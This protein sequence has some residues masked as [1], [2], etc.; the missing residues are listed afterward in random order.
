MYYGYGIYLYSSSNNTFHSII[1]QENDYYDLYIT[2]LSVSDCNNFFQNATG[3]GDRP[4]E[5]Y[6][7]SVDLQNK[8]LSELI[9]C[10]A[11]NSNITNITIIGSSTKRNNMLYVCRTENITVSKINSSYN[12]VGVYLSSSNSTTLQNI[13][14]NS[15]YEGIR[16]SSSSSNTLQN[17]T[18]NSNNYGIRLS[19]SDNNTLQNITSNYNNYYGIYLLFSSSSNTFQN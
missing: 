14:T 1:L 10:N 7:Y 19:S 15:N 4:I 12:R 11:D 3:S 18:A 9:L 17:I 6:N 5:Y 16:L 13:T 2:A 8:T